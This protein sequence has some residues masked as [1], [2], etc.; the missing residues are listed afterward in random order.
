MLESGNAA[1]SRIHH[2]GTHDPEHRDGI[3][4]A[5]DRGYRTAARKD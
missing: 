4:A 5:I 2:S 1:E 3:N